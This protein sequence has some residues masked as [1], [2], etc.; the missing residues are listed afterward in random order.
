M[1]VGQST[2]SPAFIAKPF[3]GRMAFVSEGQADSSQARRGLKNLAQ[4]LPW[5]FGLMPEALK[6]RPLTRRRGLF[7][8][9]RWPLQGSSR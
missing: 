6:G 9:C 8:K 1:Q 2:D 3:D 7:P 4:G 5:V